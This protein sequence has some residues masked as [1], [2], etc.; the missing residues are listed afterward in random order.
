VTSGARV[1]AR[2]KSAAAGEPRAD[3][4][5]DDKDAPMDLSTD[6]RF[7]ILDLVALHGHLMDDGDLDRLEEL[8]SADIVYDLGDFGR[9]SLCGVEAIR[10]AALSLGQRNP[11]AHHVTNVLISQDQAVVRVR[12]KGLAVNID[13]SA[14]SVV[15]E[16]VVRREADGWR[17][18][19]RKVRARREPL[20]R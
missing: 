2:A 8:F 4:R 17:I 3:G 13:G 16:D 1:S 6:D 11:L 12:S 19:Y 18:T 9:G 20:Q 15:Y 5:A 10:A 14:G 7:A